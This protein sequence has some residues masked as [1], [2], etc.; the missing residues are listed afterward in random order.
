MTRS[1]E[2]QRSEENCSW[3]GPDLN[4]PLPAALATIGDH[5]AIFLLRELM[6]GKMSFDELLLLTKIPA[7]DLRASLRQLEQQSLVESKQ[8]NEFPD[9]Y[10]F[11]ATAKG[12]SL[13]PVIFMMGS[14]GLKWHKLP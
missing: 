14:W 5:Q 8:H 7:Q 11:N 3:D 9:S 1:L 10:E 6:T 12:I 2:I 13:A 4:C